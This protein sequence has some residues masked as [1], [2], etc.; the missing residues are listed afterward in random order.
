MLWDR[1]QHQP[2]GR[3]SGKRGKDIGGSRVITL[4]RLLT[5]G[6]RLG[7]GLSATSRYEF[8]A[9]RI[10][11]EEDGQDGR[12]RRHLLWLTGHP[13]SL[14]WFVQLLKCIL[15]HTNRPMEA[16]VKLDKFRFGLVARL[17]LPLRKRPQCEVSRPVVLRTC[18]SYPM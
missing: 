5:C 10:L 7:V 9:Y 2:R 8:R 18:E 4:L 6:S 16:W 17:L 12:K 15:V 3:G 11:P 13:P 14:R 1:G